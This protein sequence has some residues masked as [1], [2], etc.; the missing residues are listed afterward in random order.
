MTKQKKTYK[1]YFCKE[2]VKIKLVKGKP[3]I[4]YI[5]GKLCCESDYFRI[6]SINNKSNYFNKKKARAEAGLYI[7]DYSLS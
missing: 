6:K 2:I 7:R 4:A 1:C 3:T 5:N